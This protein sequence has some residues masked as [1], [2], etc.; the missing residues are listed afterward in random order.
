MHLDT[1]IGKRF[2]L[3]GHTLTLL[4]GDAAESLADATHLTKHADDDNGDFYEDDEDAVDLSSP[5]TLDNS[6]EVSELYSCFHL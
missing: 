6:Q 5:G 3:L 2:T 4:A 1:D